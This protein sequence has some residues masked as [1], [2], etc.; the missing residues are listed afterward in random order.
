MPDISN[1]AWIDLW[2]LISCSGYQD[3]ILNIYYGNNL[4]ERDTY[5]FLYKL[6]VALRAV[7]H[8]ITKFKKIYSCGNKLELIDIYTTVTEA[9]GRRASGLYNDWIGTVEEIEQG[10]N[11]GDAGCDQCN[12]SDSDDENDDESDDD[13]SVASSIDENPE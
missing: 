3:G 11:F 9:E 7:G 4:S 10:C 6:R 13:E 5:D 2:C 1:D 12:E 8:T